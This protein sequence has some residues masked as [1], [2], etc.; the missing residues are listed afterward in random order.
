MRDPLRTTTS[1]FSSAG[2]QPQA[3]AANVR[4]VEPA[5][6]LPGHERG[7]LYM[8]VEVTGSGGGHP[9]I[10]RRIL[11]AAQKAFYETEGTPSAALQRAMRSAHGE[12]RKVNDAL[13]EADWRAG[14]SCAVLQGSELTIAQVNPALVVVS[15]AKTVDLFPPEDQPITSPLGGTD[16]PDIQLVRTSVEPGSIIVL[17]ENRWLDKVRPEVLA[18]AS[19]AETTTQVAEYLGQ[20]AGQA[21]LS[22]LII[23]VSQDIPQVQDP[24][25]IPPPIRSAEG[26]GAEAAAAT[27]VA[28]TAVATAD[29]PRRGLFGRRPKPPKAEPAEDN[30]L[31]DAEPMTAVA[32]S[33]ATAEV[34]DQTSDEVPESEKEER[35][36]RSPWPLILALVIIPLLIAVVVFAMWWLRNRTQDS[37]FTKAL[38]G[39]TAAIASAQS[40]PD[41]ATARQRLA[42]AKEFLD[43]AQAIKPGDSRLQP[44]QNKYD[45]NINRIDHITP[46]YGMVPLWSFSGDGHNMARVIVKENK[47][48]VFDRGLQQI[49][50]FDFKGTGDTVT[51]AA[52]PVALAKRD[53]V[54]GSDQVVADLVDM[55]WV[56]AVSNQSSRLEALD[57]SGALY[58]YDMNFGA[59][60]LVIGGRDQWGS[61]QLLAGYGGN[62]YAVDPKANQIWRYKPTDKGYEN[63]PERYFPEGSKVDL[64]GAQS[65][66]IDGNI[67]LLFADGRL[68]KYFGGEQKPFEI[69]GLPTPLSSPTAIAASLDGDQIYVADT[70][71]GR[72][73]ELNKAGDF[74]RQFRPAQGNALKEM[75]NLYLDE[76]GGALYILTNS[77][78]I[79][80][81]LPRPSAAPATPAVRATATPQK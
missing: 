39:A 58:N 19:T 15:N 59:S 48:F 75:R 66:A 54:K 74:Q 64:T 80:A 8:L 18:A 24:T 73:V 52:T 11:D 63:P 28:A 57:N 38:E 72:I 16:R 53:Q 12:L 33:G 50:R 7:N 9:A 20:L 49:A 45:D 22:A 37:D 60:P 29:G 51:P 31:S 81:N 27:V 30:T 34:V 35:G 3:R 36:R 14:M 5:A 55:T 71:N 10:Y 65:I 69:K 25:V 26:D 56:D 43:K 44:V 6:D 78:L 17:A 4:S 47:A 41:D 32:L 42:A 46:L 1:Q 62:L 21:E 77:Q 76:A 2:G 70:G 23:G 79:K 67:W 61:P 13:P 68:L 40:L